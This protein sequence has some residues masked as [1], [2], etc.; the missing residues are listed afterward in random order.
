MTYCCNGLL[1]ERTSTL[2]S[3]EKYTNNDM[4]AVKVDLRENMNTIEWFKNDKKVGESSIT[5]KY[6]NVNL[7]FVVITYHQDALV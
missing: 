7:F 5:L 2:Y 3:Y 4:I 6:S 1:C